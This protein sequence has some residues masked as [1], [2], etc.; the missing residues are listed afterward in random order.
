M[1]CMVT[2]QEQDVARRTSSAAIVGISSL[3]RGAAVAS[4][5]Q[6]FLGG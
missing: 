6:W 4:G 2:E 3:R 5:G 1:L